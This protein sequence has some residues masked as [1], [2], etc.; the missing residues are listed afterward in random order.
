MIENLEEKSLKYLLARLIKINDIYQGGKLSQTSVMDTNRMKISKYIEQLLSLITNY[1]YK[2]L[3]AILE[4]MIEAAVSPNSN[5]FENIWAIEKKSRFFKNADN[6]LRSK[7]VVCLLTLNGQRGYHHNIKDFKKIIKLTQLDNS[8]VIWYLSNYT[9]KNNQGCYQAINYILRG[10]QNNNSFELRS[11][12]INWLDSASG[13][14]PKKAWLDNL[15]SIENRIEKV[16]LLNITNWIITNK[17]LE[18]E[19][20]TG[21]IDDVFKRF[22]K[23]A[24]WYIDG[25]RS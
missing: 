7:A 22:Q 1:T 8:D 13:S 5:I 20:N 19:L 4:Y 9:V 23:S 2:D 24:K 17:H 6:T 15:S 12:I 3:V 11:D 21:W 16:D 14:S 18:R 10:I 25:I